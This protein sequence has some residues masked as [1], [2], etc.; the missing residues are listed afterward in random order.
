[1][2]EAPRSCWYRACWEAAL[3]TSAVPLSSTAGCSSSAQFL[4]QPGTQK[5]GVVQQWLGLPALNSAR[6]LPPT[7]CPCSCEAAAGSPCWDLYLPLQKEI[8]YKPA[9][10]ASPSLLRCA[11]RILSSLPDLFREA[12][13]PLQAQSSCISLSIEAARCGRIA[14]KDGGDSGRPQVGIT[15]WPCQQRVPLHRSLPFAVRSLQDCAAGK[16]DV[17][18]PSGVPGCGS[19]G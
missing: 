10:P 5:A 1:M 7:A 16:G 8:R 19:S 11:A 14:L 12:A 6:R 9:A 18:A 4:L 15:A 13:P 3:A 17:R 2:M